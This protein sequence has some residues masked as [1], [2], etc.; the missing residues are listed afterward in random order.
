MR[1]LVPG[2]ALVVVATACAKP[3][4]APAGPTVVTVTAT[5]YAF[6]VP[7]TL[8]AALT[9][10]RLVNH[11]A[12]VHHAVLVRVTEPKTT[13]EIVA[14]LE[15]P[16]TPAWIQLVPGPSQAAPHDSSNATQVLEPGHYVLACFIP[17]PDG[18]PHVAK[19]MM[20][21]L[22]VIGTVPAGAA[23][24]AADLTITLSDY[25]FALSAPLTAGTHTIRVE[26]TGPQMHEV[27]IERLADGKTLADYQAWAA[28]PQ[29]PPPTLPAG[30]LIGPG[31]GGAAGTFTVTLTP[32]RYL[33]TCYVPGPDGKPHV[34]HGMVQEV[35]IG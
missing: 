12:E 32:G 6:G 8:A 31:P 7:D 14:A 10:L 26:N 22:H 4:P 18:T 25:A 11:G 33:L 28:A 34:A 27:T 9:E 1:A 19:G 3:A 13:A 15:S 30:G 16:E 21:E 17:S 29:G 24:P 35:V 23:L 20:K 2:A 5:D